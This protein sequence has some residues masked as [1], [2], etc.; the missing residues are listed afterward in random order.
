MWGRLTLTADGIA[1]LDI[2]DFVHLF[3]YISFIFISFFNNHINDISGFKSCF[4]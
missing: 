3:T 1:A 4:S 2:I